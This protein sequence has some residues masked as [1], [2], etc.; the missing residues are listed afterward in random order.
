MSAL[1]E[2]KLWAI[3]EVWRTE[4]EN[5]H[6]LQTFA[7]GLVTKVGTNEHPSQAAVA[8][9]YQ[10]VEVDAAWCLPVFIPYF[11]IRSLAC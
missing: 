7:A 10:K 11:F 9:F 6:G 3:R 2:A 8:K 1:A 5:D 4:H